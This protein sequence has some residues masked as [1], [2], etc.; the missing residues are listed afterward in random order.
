MY[1][2]RVEIKAFRNLRS[3]DVWL[4]PGLNVLVGR[5][6]TGKSTLLLAIRHALGPSSARGD[7]PLWLTEDDLHRGAGGKISG[8]IRITLTFAEL[9]PAQQAQFLEI[10]DRG[11][12]GTLSVARI[13]FEA[14]WHEKKG[15]FHTDRW[16][17]PLDGDR[18]AIPS[19][20]LESLPVTFLPALRDAEAALSPGNKSRLARLLEDYAR[21][22]PTDGHEA[23]IRGIFEQANSALHQELLISTVADKLQKAASGMAGS[24][25]VSAAI[26]AVEPRFSRILRSL[27]IELDD[28][29]VA[30]LTSS[31]LGYNNL[32]YIAT[33]LAHLRE[34]PDDEVPLLLIEE[35]EAHL[36]PQLTVRLG[37]YLAGLLGGTPPQTIV[38]THSPTLVARVKPSQVL[39]QHARPE[40]GELTCNSL[41]RLNLTPS[42]ERK[43]QRMLDITRAT[44]YF[45]KGL[46]LVEGISE[47]LLIPELARRIGLNLSEHHISVVPICGVDFPTLLHFLCEEG[48]GVATAIITDGDPE[49]VGQE[50]QEKRPKCD[51]HGHPIA[52]DRLKGLQSILCDRRDVR[53]FPSTVTLE[54]DLAAAGESNP[55]VMTEIW[56]EILPRGRTLNRALL[57][58]QASLEDRALTVWRGICLA[59]HSGSKAEL[60]HRLAEWLADNPEKA[61]TVPGYIEEAVRSVHPMGRPVLEMAAD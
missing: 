55:L 47:S 58:Q 34:S 18:T 26:R 22:H 27:R 33:V 30:E 57:E 9:A 4:R 16:G 32:L 59:N 7:G 14:T 20:I 56:N 49:V 8:P 52:C 12:D 53:V 11:E 61:F 42:Q 41:F 36:H 1:L 25:Y 5:N 2:E 46:I 29:P 24:D 48:F 37:E 54:Y 35:P 10:L 23:R 6:N 21:E 40:S 3:I 51:D 45:A 43:V 38:T 15:R 44:L 19:E 31:G 28:S 17:G 13:H 50:L 60:A 39:V